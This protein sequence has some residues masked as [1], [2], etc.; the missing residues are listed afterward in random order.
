MLAMKEPSRPA[1][2]WRAK[3]AVAALAAVSLYNALIQFG[4]TDQFTSQYPDPYSVM[5]LQARLSRIFDRIPPGERV[6]YFSNV[7]FTEPAGQAA[8]FAAQYA[9][10]PRIVLKEDA[11]TANQA[12]YWLGIFVKQEDFAQKGRERGLALEQDLGGFV[13]LYRKME[14]AQ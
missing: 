14:Q 5:G 1:P 2:A 11:K 12:R 7:P 9:L 3:A 8:F 10:A 4:L 6:G 13:V